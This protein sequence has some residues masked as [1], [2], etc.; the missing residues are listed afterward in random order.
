[1]YCFQSS[2]PA[3]M[4]SAPI[5]LQYISHKVHLPLQLDKRLVHERGEC[6]ATAAR[7]V[8]GERCVHVPDSRNTIISAR[9][10]WNKVYI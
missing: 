9:G 7:V 6:P 10:Q 5:T 3:N 1:M 8:T 2:A 4:M